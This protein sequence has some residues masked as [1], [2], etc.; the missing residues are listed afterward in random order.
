MKV[1]DPLADS[2]LS[3]DTTDAQSL[4]QSG[5]WKAAGRR[6]HDSAGGTPAASTS[7]SRLAVRSP[8]A[9]SASK[10]TEF[11][12]IVHGEPPVEPI[13]VGI[14]SRS[15]DE[16]LEFT[17]AFV[18]A[19]TRSR[20]RGTLAQPLGLAAYELLGNALKYGSVV[21]E[22]VFQVLETP[23][24]VAVRVTNEAVQVRVDMLCSHLERVNKDPEGAFL[25][26]MRR[27][28]AGGIPRPMLGL[29]RVVHEA[30]LP[31]DVYLA[32]GRVTV[33]ARALT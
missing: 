4:G 9:R 19:Y 17:H 33:Q 23:K 10:A 16:V 27:S 26:E 13:I 25:E 12:K 14:R 15:H 3:K 20:F 28:V 31:L 18:V 29:A 8:A 1:P 5:T 7:E 11:V 2:P 6:A 30:K 32:G 21:G 22:V 24:S